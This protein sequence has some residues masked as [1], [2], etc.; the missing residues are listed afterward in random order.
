MIFSLSMSAFAVNTDSKIDIIKND[1]SVCVVEEVTKNG[2]TVATNDKTSNTLTIEY[3]NS[4][5]T[6][7]LSVQT[8]DLT[9]IA[10]SIND[11]LQNINSLST[12]IYQ[13]TFSN[14]EYDIYIYNTYTSWTIRSG[15]NNKTVTEKS[16]NANNLDNFRSAVED[17]NSAEFTLIGSIGTTAAATAISAFLS[18]GLAAGI[19]AAGGGAGVT[20]AFASLNAAINNAD[21][22]YARVR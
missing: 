17:V 19:A 12:H 16:S 4:A 21:Y 2:F 9:T 11:N 14:R 6:E 7:L 1:D 13:H 22:Y 20:A 18:G 10:D 3:Y 8:L 15:N 5:K